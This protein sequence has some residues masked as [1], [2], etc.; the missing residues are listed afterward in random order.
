MSMIQVS[1]LT[2]AYPGSFDN[3][4][5]DVSFQIDTDWRLGFVGRNGRGKT[6]FLNLLLGNYE[7]EGRIS[8]SVDF[9]YFPFDPP[10]ETLPV[11]ALVAALVPADVMDW[12]IERELGLLDV[13]DDALDRPLNTLS[14]GERAKVLLAALFLRENRFL[15]IDEPTNHLDQRARQVVGDYLRSKRGY[16]LVSH[17]RAFL[18]RC[19]DHILSINRADI[20]VRQGDYSSWA[21]E[22][23]LR[24][25]REQA[26][27]ERLEKDIDRLTASARRTANWSDKVEKTKYGK[28]DSGLKADRGHVGH[29]AAKMMKSAKSIERRRENAAA[30][31]STLLKNIDRADSLKLAPL[32]HPADRLVELRA[33]SIS[34]G[35]RTV[36]SDLSFTIRQGDRIALC[37]PNGSGKTSVLRLICGEPVD[38]TGYFSRASNLTI[39][40]VSQDTAGLAGGVVDYARACD[41]DE[42][43]FLTILRKLDFERVQFE[44][45]LRDLSAGQKKKIL[46]ARSLSE[47]AHLYVWDEPLNYIDLLSRV[48][49][50]DLL[51][52]CGATLLFVEHDAAF[53]ERIETMRVEL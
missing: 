30:E 38:Y 32:V 21:R 26:E 19:V 2:F 43:R 31:K 28:Q 9:D 53:T 41:V 34:F 45:D 29:M 7:Y 18:D 16:I 14:G 20:E 39:S 3:I 17:D 12:E 11:R 47:N 27:N 44:K 35:E 25:A 5:E 22:K 36:V 10:D 24:D 33:V 46:L 51:A 42:T 8:A 15:L 49:I 50:E 52:D 6:T 23:A 40:Y 4:F 1:H 37:G 48:Q 13:C